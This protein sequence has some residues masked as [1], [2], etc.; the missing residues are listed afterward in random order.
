MAA[1]ASCARD[2]AAARSERKSKLS[3]ACLYESVCAAQ[4]LKAGIT[5]RNGCVY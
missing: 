5:I 1:S 3:D 2:Y 4:I